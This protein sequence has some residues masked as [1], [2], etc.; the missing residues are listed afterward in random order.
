MY[1]QVQCPKIMQ[2]ADRNIHI[3][4]TSHTDTP[5]YMYVYTMSLEPLA[6]E[7]KSQTQSPSPKIV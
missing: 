5:R 7:T 6:Q 1:I 4:K 3:I 2:P